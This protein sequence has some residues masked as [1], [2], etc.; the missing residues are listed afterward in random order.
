M[1]PNDS[2]PPSPPLLFSSAPSW[3]QFP[4]S[5]P[6]PQAESASADGEMGSIFPKLFSFLS[7]TS[8]SVRAIATE[9]F[10]KLLAVGRLSQGG[11]SVEGSVLIALILT[12]FSPHTEDDSAARQCLAIFF[13]AFVRR[14]T[15]NL[16]V[17]ER[18]F[19]PAL[20]YVI[21]APSSSVLSK[22]SVLQVEPR[23]LNPKP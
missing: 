1:Q 6:P 18:S 20:R 15:A 21:H 4:S 10:A 13:P 7:D 23:S 8:S 11:S 17:L 19:L 14:G 2:F 5:L 12:Y 16:H 3:A 9:G 22:V